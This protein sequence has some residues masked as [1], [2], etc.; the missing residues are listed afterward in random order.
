MEALNKTQK[1]LSSVKSGEAVLGTQASK[2]AEARDKPGAT[3]A[4]KLEQMDKP[5]KR[6]AEAVE[7]AQ[8]AANKLSMREG[9]LLMK[10]QQTRMALEREGVATDDL[11]G[12]EAKLAQQIET[13]NALMNNGQ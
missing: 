9:E 7:R 1:M 11:A 5:T 10:V 13:V 6:A 8:L 4:E 2:I 3:D 12:S